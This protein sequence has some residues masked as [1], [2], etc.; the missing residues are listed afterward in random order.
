[1]PQLREL[2]L[3]PDWLRRKL[4]AAG[5]TAVVADFR[6]QA[7]R[8]PARHFFHCMPWPLAAGPAAAKPR[9]V[10]PPLPLHV[11]VLPPVRPCRSSGTCCWTTARTL[12]W[13]WRRSNCRLRRQW[14]TP[15]PP[16][17]CAASWRAA[18]SPRRCRLRCRWDGQLSGWWRRV[19]SRAAACPENRPSE[20]QHSGATGEV[21]LG[22]YPANVSLRP[23]LRAPLPQ[24]WLGSQQQRCYE[25][26]RT[27]LLSGLPRCLPPLTPSLDQAGG[28]Q[29]LALRGHTGA[30]T[31]VV[32]TPSGTD[33]VTGKWLAAGT[34][35]GGGCSGPLLPS[36]GLGH[37]DGL[38]PEPR[39]LLAMHRRLP[40]QATLPGLRSACDVRAACLP[41]RRS[42]SAP[43]LQ[44]RWTARRACGTWTLGT[45]CCCWRGTLAPSQTWQS[46]LVRSARGACSP[47][48]PA[49]PGTTAAPR[50]RRR[51][52]WPVQ[53]ALAAPRRV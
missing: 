34:R 28:L 44:P 37:G 51:C 1:M 30:V 33:A 41:P 14:P 11:T 53:A 49:V 8:E 21:C 23:C 25:D 52:S 10:H 17:C 15:V 18:L 12:S 48:G 46:P 3:D 22:T 24:A 16:A 2:L 20:G 9:P 27:A 50:R 19:L 4:A 45:A 40:T 31:K 36:A 35:L 29:R 38:Q 7:P 5:T 26:G 43:P 13:S 6:R 47:G 39:V 42:P 32:L